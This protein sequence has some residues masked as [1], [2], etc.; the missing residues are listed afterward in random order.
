MSLSRRKALAAVTVP[1]LA[2]C[3]GLLAAC[4]GGVGGEQIIIPEGCAVTAVDLQGTWNIHHVAATLDCPT[5][6]SLQTSAMVDSFAPVTVLRDESLPGFRITATGLTATG[7][8]ITGLTAE[9]ADVTC[10]IFWT[11]LDHDTNALYECFTTFHPPTRTAGGEMAA[12][13]CDQVTLLDPDGT[14]GATCPLP[15]PYLDGYIVVTGS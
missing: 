4:G 8:T 3:L 10:H 2:L 9:V 6:T 11:Y 14:T 5:G 7:Q 12:G 13:H 1:V 15:P